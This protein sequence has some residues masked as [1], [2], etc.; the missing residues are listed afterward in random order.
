MRKSLQV[1]SFL[2]VIPALLAVF[3]TPSPAEST[4]TCDRTHEGTLTID[5]SRTFLIEDETYCQTGNIIVQDNAKLIVRNAALVMS[6]SFDFQYGIFVRNSGRLEIEGVTI[7]PSHPIGITMR[8]RASAILNKVSSTTDYVALIAER[9]SSALVE[10]SEIGTLDIWEGAQVQLIDSSITIR[11]TLNFRQASVE[12]SAL[13]PRYYENWRIDHPFSLV[14]NRVNVE[15]WSVSVLDTA[16]V[17]VSRSVLDE[18]ILVF[19]GVWGKLRN[20]HLGFY[21]TWELSDQELDFPMIDVSLSD[22]AV[23]GTWGIG[24]NGGCNVEI[25]DS[26]HINLMLW[27][28]NFI[29]LTRTTIPWFGPGHFSGNL[30]F[31]ESIF[32]GLL[33]IQNSTMTWKGSVKFLSTAYLDYWSASTVGRE[34]V[35]QVLNREG[36]PVANASVQVLDPEGQAIFSGKTKGQG[37]VAFTIT[38][39]DI[40]YKESWTVT[41]PDYGLEKSIGFLTSTPVKFTVP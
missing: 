27:D 12:L 25:L 13:R 6:M 26:P 17:H 9:S 39:N 23:T 16:K 38:F 36:Q 5:G 35:I 24:F 18:L 11:V 2:V 28:W 31:N 33:N 30:Q 10:G 19:R 4:N 21:E 20:L 15:G 32:S 34:F 22:T 41:L 14:L 40:N 29:T 3:P 37:E 1:I 7:Q 8:D